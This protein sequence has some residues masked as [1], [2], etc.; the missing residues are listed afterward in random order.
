MILGITGCPGSGKSVLARTVARYG[1]NLI[2]ADEI[3]R[4][5]VEG[6]SSIIDA[7]VDAFGEDIIGPNGSLD[8]RLLARRVFVNPEATEKLNGIVHPRLIS[9]LVERIEVLRARG[10][11][12]VVDCALVFEWGIE[13]VF[14]L[15]ICVQAELERRVERIMKRDGRTRAEIEGVNA[16]Q[17]PEAEKVRRADL[18]VTNN[19]SLERLEAFARMF[20]LLPDELP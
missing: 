19:G 16:A 14:D 17:L 15:V 6:N 18:V 5:V 2:D 9:L 13:D 4:E 1:G 7:L 10:V 20:S 3:G 8:R 12:T 11:R